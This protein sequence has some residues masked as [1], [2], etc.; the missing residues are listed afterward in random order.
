MFIALVVEDEP[1]M[2]EY[3]ML[4]LTSIHG[5]WKTEGCARDGLE[6][7][8]LLK[9]KPFDLV[10][11]DIKMP[12]MDGLE[13]AD[14]IHVNHPGTDVI[15]LTGYSE[16]DYARAAVR[17]NAA[18]YLLKPLQDVELHKA[19]SKLAAKRMAA[20]SVPAAAPVPAEAAPKEPAQDD[21]G[22]LVQR[23]RTYIR[24]HF[25]EP[26]LLNEVANTLAVNPAYLS[27]IF[28]SERGESYSKFIL[29]L[30]MERAALLLRTYSAGKVN[31]IALEVGYSSTKHFYTVFKD[32]FGVT[33]NEYRNQ[34]KGK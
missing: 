20:D 10:I 13:L 17:A 33:P 4:H 32:Y 29:R 9:A 5:L 15:I 6:A 16:F 25:T 21:P 26:L 28:K 7:L 12:H 19:L 34:N 22:I 23:A 14:Y 24:A 30:R 11:T 27:S 31:D 8:A 2:R 1:L 18:D 3:L